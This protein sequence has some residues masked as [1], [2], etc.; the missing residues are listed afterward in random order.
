MN[1]RIDEGV[2][3]CIA[4]STGELIERIPVTR[5]EGVAAAVARAKTAQ[6][7]WAK[8]SVRERCSR[9]LEM[10][11]HLV[12]ATDRLAEVLVRE[13]GKPR[14]EGVF[15]E[16]GL[17]ASLVT[18]FAR[19]A[20]KLLTARSFVP[21]VLKYRRSRVHYEPRGVV[22]I[23]SPWNFPLVI[24]FG[25]A[26]TALFA[27]NAVV[28]KPSEHAP[29]IALEMKKVWDESGLDPD[30]LQIVPGRGETGQALIESGV[31]KIVFTGGVETGR[32][33]AAACGQALVECVLELG[34]KAPAVVCADADVELTARAITFGGFFNAGQ[35]CISIERVLA[36]ESVYDALVEQISQHTRALRLGGPEGEWDVGPLI[37]PKQGAVAEALIRDALARGA[38]LRTGGKRAERRGDFFEPTVLAGC[39]NEMRVMREEIFGPVLP[40]MKVRDDEQAIE[41]ANSVPLGLNAYVFSKKTAHARSLAKRLEVGSVVINDVLSDYG[42]PEAP[43][44]GVKNSGYGRTHGEESLRA[45]CTPKHVS[46][47]RFTPPIRPWFPYTELSEGRVRRLVSTLFSK[48]SPLSGLVGRV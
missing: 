30:L 35:A 39:T 23:I 43:F 22:G 11:E 9:M 14:Q 33:V 4:P 13:C 29:L 6:A 19:R 38:Q 7:S 17:L 26:F 40:I 46:E 16:V 27:G 48:K 37:F 8:L 31:A 47:D 34:G 5:P 1:E 20:P 44:G 2:I 24:P 42:S 21:S 10:R 32:R 45:M 28:I 12:G 41:I 15:H 3:D 18:H 25:D 36:H